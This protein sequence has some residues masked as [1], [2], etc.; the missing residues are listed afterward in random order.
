LFALFWYLDF[1]DKLSPDV[2]HFRGKIG[3]A[4]RCAPEPLQFLFIG[5][6]EGLQSNTRLANLNIKASAGYVALPCFQ[7]SCLQACNKRECGAATA[8]KQKPKIGML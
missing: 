8:Q 3:E 7:R 5:G 2:N 1:A 6:W 4:I